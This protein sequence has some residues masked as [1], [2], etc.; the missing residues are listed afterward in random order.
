MSFVAVYLLSISLLVGFSIFVLRVIV[1]RDYLQRGHLSIISAILQAMLF[2]AFGG[3]PAIYL[4]GDWPISH[5]SLIPRVIGLACLSIGL[6][7]MFVSIYR[8]GILPSLGMQS[9]VLR[10]T[11][12][13]HLS[14][15]PQV[16]GCVC[17]V[18]GFCI[19]WPS[20]YALGWG[21]SL[22]AIL[23]AMVFMEEEHLSNAYGQDYD[24]YRNTVSRYL[25]YPRAM[26]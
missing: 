15:N 11:S 3:F 12:L 26:E 10:K 16:L 6:A 8:L 23:H 2:F 19:L 25:G 7:V 5:V 18:M 21:I 14:R 17:Y 9:G 22:L 13:Y 24:D 20:W 4:P 1:R